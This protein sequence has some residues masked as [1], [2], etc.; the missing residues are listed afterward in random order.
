MDRLAKDLIVVTSQVDE[1]YRC[2]IL[3]DVLFLS[4]D[5]P[6]TSSEKM[7]NFA[8]FD[9]VIEFAI[10]GKHNASVPERQMRIVPTKDYGDTNFITGMRAFAALAV[11]VIHSGGAGLRN[12]G[13]WGINLA[14][15]GRTGPYVFFCRVGI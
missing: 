10:H 5:P 9:S 13:Q 3:P 11:V 8:V 1:L 14:D 6:L 4:A 7:L 15:I 2:V 12:L